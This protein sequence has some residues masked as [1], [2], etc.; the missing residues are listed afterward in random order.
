M[1]RNRTIGLFSAIAAVF[2]LGAGIGIA[3]ETAAKKSNE[4]AKN[5]SLDVRVL[6]TIHA[7]NAIEVEAGKLAQQKGQ[8]DTVRKLGDRIA[9]DHLSS[10]K[11]VTDLA[12]KKKV[13][14][15]PVKPQT[16]EEK[17]QHEKR[18]KMMEKLR[19]LQGSEFDSA[20]LKFMEEGHARSIEKLQA[21]REKLQDG[22]VRDLV[23]KLLPILEQH[24]ELA[25]HQE[26][27]K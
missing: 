23:N 2:L 14:L 13:E 10:D 8:S 6:S 27:H 21:S 20:F 11:M 19:N 16:D 12:H 26:G 9:R 17:Q 1:S 25:A 24:R 5:P 4:A 7:T 15:D 22:D 3:Q 18:V